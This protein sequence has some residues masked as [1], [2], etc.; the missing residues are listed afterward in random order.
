MCTSTGLSDVACGSSWDPNLA[1]VSVGAQFHPGWGRGS[2][3]RWTTLCG[4]AHLVK[5]HTVIPRLPLIP[6]AEVR[7]SWQGLQLSHY[8]N[9]Y[10]LSQTHKRTTGAQKRPED[11]RKDLLKHKDFIFSLT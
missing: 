8:P 5:R 1:A 3:S 4:S 9:P 10:P 7:Q 11:V 2:G 6:G